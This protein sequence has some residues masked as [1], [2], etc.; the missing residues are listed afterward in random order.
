MPDQSDIATWVIT[1]APKA[2]TLV[3]SQESMSILA[4]RSKNWVLSLGKS[5]GSEDG[6]DHDD[7]SLCR[8]IDDLQDKALTFL[9]RCD[10]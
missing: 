9:L 4:Y 8:L 7:D 5:P 1:V 10:L 3:L 2:S 6:C